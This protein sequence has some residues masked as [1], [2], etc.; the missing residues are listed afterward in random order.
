MQT[1]LEYQ[2]WPHGVN[3]QHFKMLDIHSTLMWL[4]T[5]EDVTTTHITGIYYRGTHSLL[6]HATTYC[7]DL[8]GA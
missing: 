3:F 7:H 5:W 2:V 6:Y 4:S 1:D 8:E